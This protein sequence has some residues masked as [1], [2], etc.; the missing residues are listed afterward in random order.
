MPGAERAE[1]IES[2]ASLAGLPDETLIDVIQ[3][4]TFDYFW[5][6][7]HP[8]SGLALDRCR[9]RELTLR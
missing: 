9:F 2:A 4:R 8:V 5:A 3:R 7:A 1:P 6:G